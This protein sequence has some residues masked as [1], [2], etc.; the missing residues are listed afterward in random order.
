MAMRLRKCTSSRATRASGCKASSWGKVL[1]VSI[2]SPTTTPASAS[3][4]RAKQRAD[5]RGIWGSWAYRVLSA[6]DTERIA[7]LKN[8]YQLVEGVVAAVGEAGGR[9][10]LNFAKDWRS[11]FIIV[12]EGTDAAAF[13]TAGMEPKALA[14]K[15]VRVRGWV[16]WRNG[17]MIAAS[18]PEQ[19]E[20]LP[21]L[22]TPEQSDRQF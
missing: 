17:P 5:Q 6:A 7:R 9:F 20:L 22:P 3:C 10:Y 2:P 1:P 13:K 8:T 16:E 11:D 19:I 14:G 21:D 4:S 18:H 12:V 15:R